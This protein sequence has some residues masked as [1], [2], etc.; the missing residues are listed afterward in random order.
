MKNARR[1]K[2]KWQQ[3]QNKNKNAGGGWK[4]HRA[5]VKYIGI[6][7]VF[8]LLIIPQLIYTGSWTPVMNQSGKKT[9]AYHYPSDRIVIYASSKNTGRIK[10]RISI[11]GAL[12]RN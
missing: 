11:S 6:M 10:K 9:I 8:L 2:C 7:R 5:S 3:Q 12:N 1:K 4:C